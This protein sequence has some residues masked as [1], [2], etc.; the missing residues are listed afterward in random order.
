MVE[1]S[2]HGSAASAATSKITS[3]MLG[4]LITLLLGCEGDGNNRP[5]SITQAPIDA[6]CTPIG[7]PFPAGFDLLPEDPGSAVSMRFSPAGLLRFDLSESPPLPDNAGPVPALP[8]DSDGDGLSD[9]QAFRDAGLC[10][11]PRPNCVTSPIVGSARALYPGT[12]LVTTSGYEEVLFYNSASGELQPFLLNAR[13]LDD[14]GDPADRPLF[15]P[16]GSEALRTGLSTMVCVYPET[17]TD[18]NGQ[19]IEPSIHC[20]PN[21]VGFLTRF[22]AA[23]GA[24]GDSLFVA[25]SNL[26]SPSLSAFHPGTVLVHRVEFD[27]NG[28]PERVWP[29]PDQPVIWT[30]GFNPTSLTPHRTASGR[31]LMRVTQTGAVDA[32]GNLLSD[33]K[34][35][36]IDVDQRRIVATIPLGRAGASSEGLTLGSV[37]PIAVVGAESARQLYVL[38]FS[39]LDQSEIYQPRESPIVLDGSTPDFP[40]VRI[41]WG[42]SPLELLSR[43]DGPPDG[44]CTTRVNATVN[45]EGDQ[46][47]ATDWCDGTLSI[48]QI[49]WR[50]PLEQPL[51]P[52]RFRLSRRLD[53]FAPKWPSNFGL[54]AAPS[55]PKVRPGQPGVDFEGPDLFF[56]INEPEGQLC[57]AEV[58]APS[59]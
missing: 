42:E 58:G 49:D 51:S 56:L 16:P 35:D 22:T 48:V 18:S 12:T 15:P 25:T 47:Y 53:W 36:V 54:A 9:A 17:R 39:I 50:L 57:A 33:S 46:I 31:D 14:L 4:L 38:D 6:R 32:A 10:P 29:D 43:P 30:T 37:G 28:R 52:S 21:R 11:A 26:Y 24:S 8:Q 7:G 41:F 1:R 44:L 34:I 40:D 59:F 19:E 27:P 13:A 5:G 55:L 2:D 45:F 23:V 20:D 3:M